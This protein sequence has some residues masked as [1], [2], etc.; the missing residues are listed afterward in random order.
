MA[1]GYAHVSGKIG[2]LLV[3]PGPGFLNAATGRY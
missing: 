3:V 1:Y 2:T